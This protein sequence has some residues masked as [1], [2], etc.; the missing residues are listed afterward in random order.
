MA[1]RFRKSFKVAPGLRVNISKKG[2]GASIGVKGARFGISPSGRA[3]T[4]ASI[5]GTGLYAI[6]YAGGSASRSSGLEAAAL[7]TGC[8]VTLVLLELVLA[9]AVP[10]VGFPLLALTG[11]VY[12]SHRQSPEQKARRVLKRA[13][14]LL[15]QGDYEGALP[16]LK[17]ACDVAPSDDRHFLVAGALNNVG[18]FEEALPHLQE[19]HRKD[20]TNDDVTLLLANAY[21]RTGKFDEAVQLAQSI[22]DSS[23]WYVKAVS[24]VG[25]CFAEQKKY[26]LAIEALKN[27]PL[28]K[29]KLDDDLKEIHYNLAEAYLET[30]NKKKA[31]QHFKRVFTQDAR[32]R[33]VAEKLKSLRPLE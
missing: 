28:Q 9:L 2:I 32:Y 17:E 11:F 31:E 13:A 23:S 3:Y 1:W 27:A 15:N 12:Y 33:D 4:S 30:G 10:T 29:R 26:D 7:G 24:M 19:L 18:R 14:P 16:I 25:C 22:P 6:S 20:P 8:L 5:P 21:Y